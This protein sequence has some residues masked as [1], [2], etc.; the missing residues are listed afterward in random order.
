MH[1]MLEYLVG[2]S[3]GQI[4]HWLLSN[5]YQ[6]QIPSHGNIFTPKFFRETTFGSLA[7]FGSL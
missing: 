4:V 2:A 6:A 7:I 1:A 3:T 5:Q